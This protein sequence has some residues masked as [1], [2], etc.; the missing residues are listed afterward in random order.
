L[1]KRIMSSNLVRYME[2]YSIFLLF[3]V[4]WGFTDLPSSDPSRR[5]VVSKLVMNRKKPS[6][7]A[8]PAEMSPDADGV[9]STCRRRQNRSPERRFSIQSRT[10]DQN[11]DSYKVP[12]LC[13]IYD[14]CTR[15]LIVTFTHKMAAVPL[16]CQINAIYRFAHTSQKIGY[17]SAKGPT[18]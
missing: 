3:C 13:A 18:G 10:M 2:A 6:A 5:F 12:L 16:S 8:A 9:G 11:C 15:H 17:P 4:V 14:S 7:V 1:C